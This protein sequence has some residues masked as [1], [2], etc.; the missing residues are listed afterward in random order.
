MAKKGFVFVAVML[1][2]ALPGCLPIFPPADVQLTEADNGKT[3]IIE[4]GQ[5]VAVTLASNASTGFYWLLADLDQAILEQTDQE[6][7]G[8]I[9]ELPGA[10]GSERWEF[11]ARAV[12]ATKLRL[13]YVGPS[14]PEGTN[15]AQT[16]EVV[17]AVREPGDT[18]TPAVDLQLTEQSDDGVVVLPVTGKV[19]VTLESNGSTGYQ[20]QLASLDQAILENTEQTYI[21][22]ET[23]LIGAAGTER[24]VFVARHAGETAL[25]ME[26]RRPWEPPETEPARTFSV[27]VTVYSAE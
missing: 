5:K 26:Y 25:R 24:W 7:I 1:L 9:L 10:G 18:E 17:V 23:E 13:V 19:I 27:T 20:W 11:T 4:V 6:Y 3:V 8:P 15:P 12:G 16:F 14:D 2:Q 22:P 21:P